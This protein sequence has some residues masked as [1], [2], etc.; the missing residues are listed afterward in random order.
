MLP[1]PTMQGPL[2]PSPVLLLIFTGLLTASL[3]PY[4]IPAGIGFILTGFGVSCIIPLVFS[5]AGKSKTM[6][7]GTALASVST[8]SY[9]GFLVVPPGVGYIAQAIGLQ[10]SFGIIS[11]F[12]AIIFLLVT[13]IRQQE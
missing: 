7:S 9:F 11:V 10:W 4:P 5:L 13:F 8:I 1:A 6:S 3:L 12:G 2:L